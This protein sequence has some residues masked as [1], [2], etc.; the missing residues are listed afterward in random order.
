[1]KTFYITTPIFYPNDNL[2]IG[3]AYTSVATDTIVKYKKMQGYEVKFTTGTDDHG[4]KIQASAQKAS[5]T[6]ISYV[7]N[8]VNNIKSLWDSLNISY[9]YFV[10]TTDKN[11][12]EMVQKIF[13][14]LYDNGD[15]YLGKYKGL[16]CTPC[17]TF[18]TATNI[19]GNNCKECGRPLNEVEEEAYNFK[20]SKYISK[21]KKYIEDNQHFI[22]PN[23]KKNEIINMLEEYKTDLCVSRTSFDWGIPVSFDEKHVVY[24]WID[25]LNAYVSPLGFLT[26]NS[27][28]YKKYWPADVHIVGKEIV[29]F[30]AIIW[31]AI[32]MA[33]DM[34]LPK[35]IFVHGHL[36]LGGKKISKSFGNAV[37]PG[38]FV[39]RYG[40]DATRYFL[41]RE[42]VFGSDGSLSPEGIV[43]RINADLAN[44]LGNLLSRTVAMIDKYFN[45][46]LPQ[47][48]IVSDFDENL[49]QLSYKTV[50]EVEKSMDEFY[51]NE[52]LRDTWVFISSVNKYIDETMPWLVAKDDNK[53]AN[54][55]NI[56][57]NL[58]ESL[59]IIA[60]LISPLME[61][62]ANEIYRQL[63]ITDDNLK[64]WESAKSFGL[65]PKKVKVTIGEK[66]FPRLDKKLEIEILNKII[67]IE[68]EIEENKQEKQVREE[69][70]E[71]DIED[72]IKIKL[73]VGTVVACEAIKKSDKLLKSQVKVGDEVRQIVSGISRHYSPE[74]MLGKQVIVITNLKPRKPMGVLSQGMILAAENGEDLGLLTLD[75]EMNGA[76]VS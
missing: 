67:G 40:A 62:T 30:H 5:T 14:T 42:I 49:Q 15:I 52:A 41:M 45:G 22:K 25:A 69:S 31:P 20:I 33:M 68:Q 71:I 12:T 16:Y 64:I 55:A 38:Y 32:L 1:M 37:D 70:K 47:N 58:S 56:M 43:N 72:F 53:K 54:L 4:Q 63:N 23:S 76:T 57:Y 13:K 27:D 66:L 24:V 73:K 39:N 36:L 2:H 8:I 28:D 44:D 7:N 34:P 61:V 10:R 26:E 60:I 18:F 17:E 74:E 48:Q 50:L 29:K 6:P 35:Q 3:H 65:L 19:I 75:K 21:V 11:H 59:R 51:F 9:D 46:T